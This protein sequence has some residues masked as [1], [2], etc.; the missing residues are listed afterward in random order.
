MSPPAG[1][2]RIL[3]T[4]A[5]GFVGRHLLADLVADPRGVTGIVA[6]TLGGE[7]VGEGVEAIRGDLSDPESAARIVREARPDVVIH[8]AGFASVGQAAGMGEAAWA[9][10]FLG[11]YHLGAAVARQAPN[12]ALLFASSSEVY[13]AA[14]KN[15]PVTEDDAPAPQSVYG[16]SKL[17]AEAALADVLGPAN[18]L[19]VCRPFNHIGPGQDERFVVP[20]F[21][22]QIARIERGLQA[23]VLSVGNLTAQRDFLDVRDVVGAYR[24]LIAA[25]PG[26]PRLSTY[27]IASGRVVPISVLLER[28]LACSEA[29]IEVAPDP[30]R[31]R[32]SD[33]PVAA[34][35]AARLTAATGWRPRRDA[36]V[37]LAEVLDAFRASGNAR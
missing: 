14:F 15:G 18:R 25:A 9:G 19:I 26:L 6:A 1:P 23:P 11:S 8:L 17:A 10:N 35:S 2:G 13:G 20:A 24:A 3:V 37:T 28:L 4:G 29:E 31:L 32:A 16:R 7:P 22:A 27:N 12:A 30:A 36:L 33:I 34:G 21:A 5:G